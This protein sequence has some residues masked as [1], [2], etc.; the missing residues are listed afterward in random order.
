M[1]RSRFMD[2]LE[3]K[4]ATGSQAFGT[5]PDRSSLRQTIRDDPVTSADATDR[6]PQR[7]G[8]VDGQ[9]LEAGQHHVRL[10][11][12]LLVQLFD[13]VDFFSAI[14]DSPQAYAASTA[15]GSIETPGPIVEAR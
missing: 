11:A 5:G 3:R 1:S 6:A 12:E 14:H 4:N 15:A 2:A 7:V 9:P 13:K 10:R 8:L